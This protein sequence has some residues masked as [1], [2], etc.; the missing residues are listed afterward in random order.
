MR[1]NAIRAVFGWLPKWL[2][3]FGSVGVDDGGVTR[4]SKQVESSVVVG[5]CRRADSLGDSAFVLWLAG[6]VMVQLNH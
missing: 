2:E 5:R 1:G 6:T 4:R 3:G